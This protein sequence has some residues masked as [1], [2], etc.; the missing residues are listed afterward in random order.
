MCL[1]SA[2]LRGDGYTNTLSNGISPTL[3]KAP[4][5][6]VRLGAFSFDLRKQVSLLFLVS[7]SFTSLRSRQLVAPLEDDLLMETCMLAAMQVLGVSNG[8]LAD[9]QAMYSF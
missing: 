4:T 9:R 1:A 3:A 7:F 5:T 8:V 2:A 6:L